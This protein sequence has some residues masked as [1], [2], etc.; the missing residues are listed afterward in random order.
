MMAK[1][2]FHFF[3]TFTKNKTV[4]EEKNPS[5]EKIIYKAVIA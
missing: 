5:T 1:Y 3:M 4:S 2:P